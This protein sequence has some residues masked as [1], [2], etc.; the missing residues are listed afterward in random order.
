MSVLDLHDVEVLFPVRQLLFQRCRAIADFY[1]PHCAVFTQTRLL[2]TAK[3]LGP[4]NRSCIEGFSLDGL[5]KRLL[6][7]RFESGSN[8]VL[9]D[10]CFSIL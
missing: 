9:H 6:P 10:A 2:H 7:A 5:P 3:I 4:G 1:P 8:K